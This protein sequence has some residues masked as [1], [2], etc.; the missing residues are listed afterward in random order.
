MRT[1]QRVVSA[2]INSPQAAEVAKY[3]TQG[4]TVKETAE[5]FGVST[6]QVNN[7]AK[8][9]GLTN[10]RQF[11]GFHGLNISYEILKERNK[12]R[13]EEA[14]QRLSVTLPYLGFDYL[15]GYETKQSKCKI[16]CRAC[17]TEYERTGDFLRKGNVTCVECRKRE[18]DAK[19]EEDD[20]RR[21]KKEQEKRRAEAEKADA[22]FH[23]Q[24]D[25]I[26]VCS[27]CGKNFSVLDFVES[28]GLT[29][30]PT[31]PKYCS[32]ECNRK[33]LNKARKKSPCGKTGNYY[34]RARKYGCEYVPGITLK[35]LV[36][37]DG[38]TCR[39][40]GGMCDWNDRSWAGCFGPTYPSIDH[41]VPMSKGGGH[42]WEN[43]QVAHVM[44]NSEKGDR[45]EAGA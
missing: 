40:C 43:V 39:I 37:L 44:C 41:I 1:G 12:K 5:K 6:G 10:G 8:K 22:L 45:L 25:K 9:R 19:R 14:E 24:N 23:L 32:K 18:A 7:L 2:W 38:L 3:Y 26:H 36:A 33:A 17:G 4:H 28:K 27:V 20:K 21:A 11:H 13:S 34:D 31:N 15:G 42:V 30:I 29:L 16:R 35:K